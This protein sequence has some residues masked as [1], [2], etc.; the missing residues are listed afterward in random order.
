MKPRTRLHSHVAQSLQEVGRPPA[1]VIECIIQSDGNEI[2]GRAVCQLDALAPNRDIR[3]GCP[4]KLEPGGMD[5]LLWVDG[6]HLT[7]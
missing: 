6:E 3:A 4:P 5:G 2:I 7:S 1:E